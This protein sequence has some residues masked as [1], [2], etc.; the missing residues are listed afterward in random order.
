MTD[1]KLL[2]LALMLIELS[3]LPLLVLVI[4][5]V[6]SG[7]QMLY[8]EVYLLPYAR[9]IH[10]DPILRVLFIVLTYIHAVSG[11][12]IMISRRIKKKEISKIL[13]Y[14]I[15]VVLTLL[16]AIP[17]MLDITMR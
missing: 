3:S 2:R 8:P 13:K 9:T 12:I 7:Y 5:Y 6:Y 10:T 17:I 15:I 1:V 11:F 16:I 4:L 14:I